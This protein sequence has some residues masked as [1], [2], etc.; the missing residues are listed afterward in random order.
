MTF[1]TLPTLTV[2][3]RVISPER[4]LAVLALVF[5]SVRAISGVGR[6]K[7][8]RVAHA[9][10]TTENTI[11]FVQ[12]LRATVSCRINASSLILCVQGLCLAPGAISNAIFI[13][14]SSSDSIGVIK[15]K[16]RNK[17]TAMPDFKNHRLKRS[18]PTPVPKQYPYNK[19]LMSPND[20]T[21]FF[22]CLHISS[23]QRLLARNL[24]ALYRRPYIF[25]TTNF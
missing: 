7:N 2:P 6:V 25:H 21:I 18:F 19:I 12:K 14:S 15:R 17:R 9:Y 8:F 1:R 16:P 20:L 22:P 11:C 10:R 4:P 24:N 3:R 13:D 5:R 23:H